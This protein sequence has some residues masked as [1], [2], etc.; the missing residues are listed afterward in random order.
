[1]LPVATPSVEGVV[2]VGCVEADVSDEAGG[3]EVD[4]LPVD[5]VVTEFTEVAEA[6]S[7]EVPVV[8]FKFEETESVE[9][10]AL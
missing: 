2:T 8:S 7:V 10:E 9:V 4:A 1:M 3:A 5:V 6:V